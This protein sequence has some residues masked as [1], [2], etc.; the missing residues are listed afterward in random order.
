M[1]NS[2]LYFQCLIGVQCNDFAM[3]AAD[4]T[5][6]QSIIVMKHDENKLYDMSNKLVMGA[7]GDPGDRVQFTQFIDK[8]V[9]LYRMRNGYPL[10][11]AAAVHFT[12]KTIMEALKGGNPSMVNMLVAG[13][14]EK[15]GGQ[16]Y[17]VDFLAC[18]LRVPFG[19]HGFGGLLSL[20]ILDKYHKPD[21]TELQA[22]QIIKQCVHEV[23]ERLFI[24]L[25]NF[26]VKVIN[27][28]GI[29]EM[30]VITPASYF[31]GN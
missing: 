9:Q 26:L 8:N 25:P 13:Y 1:P 24:S 31:Q 7:I 12:R 18:A 28:D 22:Y 4:Q 21:L 27:K 11:I 2:T 14:D 5:N 16:L 30:P 29:K 23:H 15:D 17:T 3:I 6:T 19:V 20:G 10:T